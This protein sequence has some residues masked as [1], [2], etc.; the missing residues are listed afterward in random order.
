M[1]DN[2]SVLNR[3]AEQFDSVL[4]CPFSINNNAINR[5]QQMKCNVLH[6]E[7]STVT[8][9]TKVIENMSSSKALG[10]DANTAEIYKTGDQPTAEKV[11]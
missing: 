2:V 7:I 1:T 3:L 9:T 5:L 8:E 4:N 11:A 6:D 10:S